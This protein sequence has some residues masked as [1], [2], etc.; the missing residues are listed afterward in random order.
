MFISFISVHTQTQTNAQ[1]FLCVKLTCCAAELFVSTLEWFAQEKRY[2][3]NNF[4]VCQNKKKHKTWTESSHW[5]RDSTNALMP[6]KTWL[7]GLNH[8]KVVNISP[9]WNWNKIRLLLSND[10]PRLTEQEK[11]SLRQDIQL[12]SAFS[13][14][15]DKT[16]VMQ[17]P[18]F[19]W[20]VELQCLPV[21]VL[22]A[23]NNNSSLVGPNP[24]QWN[25]R[26]TVSHN[27][28]FRKDQSISVLLLQWLFQVCSFCW[29]ILNNWGF[30]PW[31][32]TRIPRLMNVHCWT[33]LMW[34][35]S[36]K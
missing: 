5:C 8:W 23:V 14:F 29:E 13:F 32:L 28:Q 2:K 27:C 24:S 7:K 16:V 21:R 3:Q 18:S 19:I 6:A 12:D 1:T 31:F 22:C 15:F 11:P 4:N 26:R 17:I 34:F 35:L 33:W 25:L 30:A 20:S 10:F 36:L 9:H